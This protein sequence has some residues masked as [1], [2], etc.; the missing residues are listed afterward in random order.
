MAPSHL[1]G[2][3]RHAKCRGIRRVAGGATHC[4][5]NAHYQ[6]NPVPSILKHFE[7]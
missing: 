6:K 4:Q 7:K 3:R 1:Q 2:W 5:K